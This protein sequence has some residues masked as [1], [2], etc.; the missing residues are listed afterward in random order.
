MGYSFLDQLPVY[1]TAKKLWE[2]GKDV[3]N[4]DWSEAGKDF[5][6]SGDPIVGEVIGEQD[7]YDEKAKGYDAV[8]AA[9][10]RMKAERMAQKEAAMAKVEAALAPTKKAMAAVYG[11]PSTWR[12]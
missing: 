5:A 2:T 11:D 7:A 3:K 4:G 1:G 6:S 12:L 10:E 9:A 8:Q